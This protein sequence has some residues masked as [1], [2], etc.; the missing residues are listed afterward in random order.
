M[1]ERSFCEADDIQILYQL[2]TGNTR[3]SLLYGIDKGNDFRFPV[4]GTPGHHNHILN[5]KR[6]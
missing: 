4:S 5:D 3:N 1:G 6:K 2:I